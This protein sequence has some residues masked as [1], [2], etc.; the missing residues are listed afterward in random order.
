MFDKGLNTHFLYCLHS[1][2]IC[3]FLFL[4]IDEWEK[5]TEQFYSCKI[6]VLVLTL[7]TRSVA[8]INDNYWLF[9]SFQAPATAF[10]KMGQG[11][12]RMIKRL[13]DFTI[14]II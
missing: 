13:K 8:G 12:D 1:V 11:Y 6:K 7:H 4:Q 3:I 5:Y 10:L 14:K 2:I 9:W